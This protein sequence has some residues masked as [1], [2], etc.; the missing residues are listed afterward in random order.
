[1]WSLQGIIKGNPIQ[2]HAD[3][4][5]DLSHLFFCHMHCFYLMPVC[6]LLW[7][8]MSHAKD[9]PP[10]PTPSALLTKYNSFLSLRAKLKKKI[11]PSHDLCPSCMHTLARSLSILYTQCARTAN[12]FHAHGSLNPTIV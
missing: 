1:M 12:R 10:W 8:P 5:C 2:I 6:L 4:S 7:K 11:A 9:K 3:H